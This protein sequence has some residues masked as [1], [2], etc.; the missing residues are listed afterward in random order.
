MNVNF[1]IHKIPSGSHKFTIIPVEAHY[2]RRTKSNGFCKNTWR[3][4]IERVKKDPYCYVIF[5]GDMIDADRP[6]MRSRKAAIFADGDRRSALN[7][8]DLDHQAGLRDGII[9]DLRP[10][11]DK[12]IGMVD[13]DHFRQYEN[14][15]TST[16]YI[17]NQLGIPKTYLG[18]RMGWVRITIRYEHGKHD[19][20]TSC[21]GLNFDI[22]VRHGK[23]SAST[24]GTDVN[25]LVRQSNGFDADLTVAGHTHRSWF[26]KVPYLYVG[27]NEIK[28]RFA[29][30]ARAGSLLRG[31]M[32]G[33]TTYPEIAE[34][35]PLSIGWPEI[36][37]YTSRYVKGSNARILSICDIK[38][39]T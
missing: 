16:W 8:E 36:Y 1:V 6:S 11:K 10:I 14:G 3:K 29:G 4:M 22:F 24:F 33:Q 32:F 23:G 7:E 30:Y 37:V 28:Q 2:S 34:Y 27:Q 19:S 5:V 9:H 25:A 39:L 12:I 31:F 18:E 20:R 26:V 21:T 15:T 13:G 17:A 35:Q 38:G